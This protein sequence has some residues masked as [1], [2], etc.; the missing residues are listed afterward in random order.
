M[1][2]HSKELKRSVEGEVGQELVV[3]HLRKKD[4][5][6]IVG[7]ALADTASNCPTGVCVRTGAGLRFFL[8]GNN[9]RK[10]GL[11]VGDPQEGGVFFARFREGENHSEHDAIQLEV[12]DDVFEEFLFDRKW[13]GARV[14]VELMPGQERPIKP[15]KKQ[16]GVPAGLMTAAARARGAATAAASVGIILLVLAHALLR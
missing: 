11:S 6:R 16:F 9:I 14:Q 12:K 1:C 4:G 10:L 5:G 13:C 2:R 3:K 15:Q 8:T 7:M